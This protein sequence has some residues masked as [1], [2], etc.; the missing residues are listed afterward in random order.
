MCIRLSKLR[1][2]CVQLYGLRLVGLYAF[3]FKIQYGKVVKRRQV[4]LLRRQREYSTA[5]A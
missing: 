1:R 5:F 4:I 2:P 3:A